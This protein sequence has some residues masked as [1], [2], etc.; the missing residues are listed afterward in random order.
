MPSKTTVL[1]ILQEAAT[2][3]RAQLEVVLADVSDA[4]FYS[5]GTTKH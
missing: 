3:A 5:D 1:R 2:V 4:T